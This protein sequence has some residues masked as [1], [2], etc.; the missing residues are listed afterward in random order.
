MAIT[1]RR[2]K[3][4]TARMAR[5]L[6]RMTGGETRGERAMRR[7][8]EAAPF[9]GAAIAGA[10]AALLLDPANGKGRRTRMRDMTAGRVRAA[11][12]L[13]ARMGRGAR[14]RAYGARQKLRH[15]RQVPKSFDDATLAQ[16]VRSEVLGRPGM[17]ADNVIVESHDGIVVL[18]G[19]IEHPEDARRLQRVIR[20]VPGVQQ[21]ESFLH[22]PGTPAPNK[23]AA[24]S[25]NLQ[26]AIR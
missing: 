4:R 17:H 11:G 9:A 20:K 25:P 18:R 19:E 7:M 3:T 23:Q 12:R 22:L 10:A 8:A 1:L 24:M 21:V 16:K 2:P 5:G 15:I 26:P 6:R 13:S 14:V